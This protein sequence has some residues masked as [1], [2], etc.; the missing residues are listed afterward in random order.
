MEMATTANATMW[1]SSPS[2]ALKRQKT[3]TALIEKHRVRLLAIIRE[4]MQDQIEAE[5][6]LQDVFVEFVEAYDLGHAI[7]TVS[8]WLIKVAQNK[9]V[10]RFRRRKTQREY[11]AGIGCRW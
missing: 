4:R 7:E 6:V 11:R 9:V 2:E 3:L 8:A 5:D 1:M 10:D